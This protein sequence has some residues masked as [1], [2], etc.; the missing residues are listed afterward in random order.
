MTVEVVMLLNSVL[1]VIRDLGIDYREL[2][3]LFARADAEGRELTDEDL[4]S[5]RIKADADIQRLREIL[6]VKKA[7]K[8]TMKVTP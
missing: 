8:P 7:A 3:K 1:M 5:L 6:A 2:S 4:S